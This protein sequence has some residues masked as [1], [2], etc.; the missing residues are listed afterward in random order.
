VETQSALGGSKVP[1][2]R[3]FKER[4]SI[5]MTNPYSGRKRQHSNDFASTLQQLREQYA[6]HQQQETQKKR[7]TLDKQV[8][9]EKELD[10]VKEGLRVIFDRHSSHNSQYGFLKLSQFKDILVLAKIFPERL[11]QEQTEV[12]YF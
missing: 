8:A 2:F 3:S 12:I 1:P 4:L 6:E 5:L 11:N 10:K 7:D 9:L